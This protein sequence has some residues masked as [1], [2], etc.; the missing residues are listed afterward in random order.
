MEIP[1]II[2]IQPHL[3]I[4]LARRLCIEIVQ[5][6][7]HRLVDEHDLLRVRRPLRLVT[8]TRPELRQR[9]LRASAVR[10]PQRQLVL[11]GLVAEIGDPFSIRRPR[12]K[13]LRHVV[14]LGELADHA[15]LRGHAEKLSARLE[16]RALARRRDHAVLD[17][18]RHILHARAQRHAIGHHR[19]RHFA[20][21]LRREIEQEKPAAIFEHDVIRPDARKVNVVLGE[22]R[23]LAHRFRLRVVGPDVLALAV[24]AI[25]EKINRRAV[26]HRQRVVRGARRH[27]FRRPFFEIEQ[28]DVRRHAAAVAFP[29]SEVGRERRVSEL[30]PVFRDCAELAVRHRQLLRQSAL[31]RHFVELPHAV[32]ERRHV[33]REVNEFA[34]RRP[35][36]HAVLRA[37]VRD[38]QRLAAG[39]RHGVDV[40]VA[41]VVSAEAEHR[42]IGRKAREFLLS[43]I[44][45]PPL[46][47]A[48]QMSP[49]YTNAICVLLTAG[50]CIIRASMRDGPAA[51]CASATPHIATQ[52]GN[53]SFI[54]Q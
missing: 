12:G 33:A 51:S 42:S 46:F 4:D 24:V 38:A 50:I 36:E 37:M 47:G 6:N 49:A 3:A 19:D 14:A 53:A 8:K 20:Q 17:Q 39:H 22:V 7:A 48:I 40:D 21:M 11:A 2:F 9:L 44:A 16:D 34:V 28:P 35:A 1:Q 54:R 52:R 5:V 23:H 27:F 15:I 26:P 41:L 18:A 45:A 13:A 25:G 32:R 10:G 31:R 43:R 29:R 30:L